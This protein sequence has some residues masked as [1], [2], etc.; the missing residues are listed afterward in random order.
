MT[1][2]RQMILGLGVLL[3]AALIKK[4]LPERQRYEE[5]DYVVLKTTETFEI[6]KYAARLEARTIVT[7]DDSKAINDGFRTLAGYIFGGNQ[8]EQQIAMTTPVTYAK[9]GDQ[10]V[11][12]VMPSEHSTNS[13]PK[14]NDARVQFIEVPEQTVAVRRFSGWSAEK[15]WHKERRALLIDLAAADISPTASPVLA[16]YDPPWTAGPLRR[17]EVLVKVQY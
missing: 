6:R 8:G 5:P 11:S 10:T 1:K 3:C 14:P 15:Q 12:F 16:Q 17:N 4:V 7:G 9:S 13:L 2:K